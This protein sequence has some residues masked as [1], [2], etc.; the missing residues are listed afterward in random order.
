MSRNSSGKLSADARA[1]LAQRVKPL[2]LAQKMNQEQLAEWANVS[3]QTLSDIE[4]GNTTP[5]AKVL[6]RIYQVL[7]VDIEPVRFEEQTEIWLSMLGTLIEAVPIERRSRAVDGAVRA[8]SGELLAP[9]NVTS[10]EA[11]RVDGVRKNYDLVAND[12]IDENPIATDAD[13]D[14]A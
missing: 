11:R 9:S 7:G 1:S 4:N 2:R 10:A 12:S 8:I 13:F 6:Q 3:R 14:N 5:Q